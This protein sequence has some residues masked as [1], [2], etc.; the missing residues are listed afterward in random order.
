MLKETKVYTE[1]EKKRFKA[2]KDAEFNQLVQQAKRTNPDPV[3]RSVAQQE[4][5]KRNARTDRY[6]RNNDPARYAEK[7]REKAAYYDEKAKSN[8]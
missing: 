1:A 7:L 3:S 4:L 6:L 2:Q 8:K 5:R